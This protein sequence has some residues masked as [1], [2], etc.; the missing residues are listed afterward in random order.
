VLIG[1]RHLLSSGGC[2]CGLEIID[3]AMI[4]EAV[5]LT[6]AFHAGYSKLLK[7]ITHAA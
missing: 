5:V 6:F 1:K 7:E 3:S 2:V 4:I